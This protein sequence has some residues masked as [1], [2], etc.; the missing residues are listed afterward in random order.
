MRGKALVFT[1][2]LQCAA[3]VSAQ[4]QTAPEL[5]AQGVALYNAGRWEEA[6]PL[7]E[8]AYS[9]VPDNTTVRRNLCN[10]HQGVANQLAKEA[11]FSSAVKHL[12][13]AVSVDPDNESPLVQLGS[14]YLRLNYV[15]EGIARLEGAIEIAPNNVD[16]HDLLGDAYYMD[17]DPSSA[18]QQWQWVR[19]VQPKRVGMSEK[20]EKASREANV[21]AAFKP[22]DSRHFQF[23]YSPGIPGRTMRRLTNILERAYI[24][25]G[26]DFGGVS[27]PTP[28]QVIAYDAKEFTEATQ[29]K[30]YVGALY[31]GKIRIPLFEQDGTPISD[32]VMR[33]RLYHEFTHVVVRFLAGDKVPWWMN[34]GLAET[35][36]K[37]LD[38]GEMNLLRQA[39][40]SGALF[41]LQELSDSQLKRLDAPTLRLAYAQAHMSM[42][43]LCKKFGQRRVADLMS[44]IAQGVSPEESLQRNYNRTYAVLEKE[45]ARTIEGQ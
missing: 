45:I 37:T 20:I 4:A 43:Y 35:F 38:D 42:N 39:Q 3:L 11:D 41:T 22:S 33:Q 2:F 32:E 24:D 36:S 23:T 19:E 16:A 21:E 27:A 34:E 8:R 13:T 30:D 15:A 44:D 1:M 6:L 25:V 18:L 12:E 14:Y 31:D 9:L 28:I 10:A 40:S 7:F 17:N 29:A 26:R 5:N